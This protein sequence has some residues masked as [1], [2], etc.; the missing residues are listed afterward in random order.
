MP[1]LVCVHSGHYIY[2]TYMN[3]Y[4]PRKPK[5]LS[6]HRNLIEQN[7]VYRLCSEASALGERSSK[8]YV[9]CRVRETNNCWAFGAFAHRLYL[10]LNS[11]LVVAIFDSS[12]STEVTD[13]PCLQQRI[14]PPRSSSSVHWRAVCSR[15]SDVTVNLH[16]LQIVDLQVIQRGN[17]LYCSQF[18]VR[19]RYTKPLYLLRYWLH[20]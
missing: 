14:S 6:F 15:T 3:V 17:S 1:L 13:L 2:D 12:T 9:G 10:M 16:E 8:R 7:R 11:V 5:S 19:S 18:H 20:K 4:I